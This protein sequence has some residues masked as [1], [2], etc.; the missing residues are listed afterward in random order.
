[1][2]RSLLLSEDG[3]AELKRRLAR[4]VSVD[5]GLLVVSHRTGKENQNFFQASAMP[6]GT[7]WTV[8]CGRLGLSVVIGSL[9]DVE[10]SAE[11][12]IASED[13][14]QIRL[15]RLKFAED[16][17]ASLMHSVASGLLELR[18]SPR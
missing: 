16:E 2:E 14:F 11:S 9:I 13:R 18:G 10:G 17:C 6:L 8:T 4:S 15:S 12:G 5:R 1:M 3:R 7:P